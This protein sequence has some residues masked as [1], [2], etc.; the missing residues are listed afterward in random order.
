MQVPLKLAWAI[1]IHKSQGMTLPSLEVELAQCFEA[2]Q[3]YVA[4]SRAVSL[5]STRILSFDAS[6]V[7]ANPR[8]EAFYD[9]IEA[10]QA[11]TL[12]RGLGEVD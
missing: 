5:S 8:V 2:G 1:S 6:R 3:A 10:R 12:T 9:R 11:G 4:L 7:K